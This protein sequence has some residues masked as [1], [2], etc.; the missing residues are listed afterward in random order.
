LGNRHISN[1]WDIAYTF[2][3]LVRPSWAIPQR[4]KVR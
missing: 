1:L 2:D 3:G 4:S